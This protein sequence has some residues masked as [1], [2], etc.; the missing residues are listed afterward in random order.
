MSWLS[1]KDDFC[2]FCMS[3]EVEKIYSLLEE[4]IIWYFKNY[5]DKTLNSNEPLKLYSKKTNLS[6]RDKKITSR[7]D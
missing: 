4:I 7:S 5:K 1:R 2:N 6:I 3:E